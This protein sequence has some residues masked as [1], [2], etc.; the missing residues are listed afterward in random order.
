MAKGT[1][2]KKKA[3]SQSKERGQ[4]RQSREY[5]GLQGGKIGRAILP[6]RIILSSWGH[7]QTQAWTITIVDSLSNRLFSFQRHTI[8][9]KIRTSKNGGLHAYLSTARH[10]ILAWYQTEQLRCHRTNK[11]L[12]TM[13]AFISM[14]FKCRLF[15]NIQGPSG[16]YCHNY[17]EAAIRFT[18]IFASTYPIQLTTCLDRFKI[19]FKRE[20]VVMSWFSSLKSFNAIHSGAGGSW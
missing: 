20:T 17:A 4:P 3:L 1:L 12:A 14:N 6:T 2:E 18:Q 8:Q 7:S 11:G 19:D 13:T 10:V 16:L 15:F 9:N 5:I